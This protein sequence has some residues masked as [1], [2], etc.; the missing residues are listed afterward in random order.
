MLSIDEIIVSKTALT[1]EDRARLMELL[2]EWQLLSDLSFADL[3]LWIPKRKDYQSWPDGHIAMAHIRPTTAATVFAHDVIG[4]VIT[5]GSNPRIDGALSTGEIDRDSEAELVGEILIK[6]ETVPVYFEGRII[7]VISRHR[8]A[9]LMRSPSRLELNY[10]E[11]AHKIYQMVAEGTFPIQNSFYR[12]ES[13]PR[14]GDGL[15]RLDA[16]GLITYASPNARSAFNRAGW[17]DELEGHLLGDVIESVKPNL[18][19]PTDESWRSILSGK[20]LRR[21]EFENEN[22]IFDLLVMP[23]V[24]GADH[25]GAIILLHNVTELRRRDRALVTKDVTIR[26]IHHRVKNNLQTVSALLR[27]QSRRVEDATAK[28][29][30]EE[31]VRRVASIAIVHETLSNSSTE[32]VSFDEVYDRIVHNAIE[33]STHKISVKKVGSF[34][35]FDSQVATPLALV[36]TELIHNALEHGL[37]D[38]GENLRVEIVR[39]TKN[40]EVKIIDDGAGLPTDFNWDQSSNLGLQIVKTLTENELKGSIQLIRVGSETQA[41]LKF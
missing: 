2:A 37:A 34:G 29:A 21:E 11:I 31:A 27:L 39:S 30:L 33:L 40:C 38:S 4:D 28:N 41:V 35:T 36:I 9:E 6:E 32:S 20:N 22:G 10:R 16:S 7:A 17:S 5:W 3:I 24:A 18:S 15:V 26:E 8:N 25:I 19:I 14:V 1:D 23:L 12:S 13:A